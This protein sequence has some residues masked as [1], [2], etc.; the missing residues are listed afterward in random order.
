MSM[1][2]GEYEIRDIWKKKNIGTTD[3]KYNFEIASH[4]VILLKLTKK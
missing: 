2:N 4:D 3:S 1:L